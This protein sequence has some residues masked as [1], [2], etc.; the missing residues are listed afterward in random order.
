MASVPEQQHGEH[1]HQHWMSLHVALQD[2]ADRLGELVHETRAQAPNPD[3]FEVLSLSVS[4][5]TLPLHGRR[6]NLVF[7]LA[8]TTVQIDMAVGTL[9]SV[10]LTAGWNVL[11]LE[12]GARITLTTGGPTTV[13]YKCTDY[14]VA[15]SLV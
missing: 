12:D 7:C 8:A 4:P 1:D 14:A 3:Y 15:P 2:I 9:P 6:H 11:D 5:L 10:N 13:L